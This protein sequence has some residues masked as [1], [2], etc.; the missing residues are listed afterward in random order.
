MNKLCITLVAIVIMSC[1][2]TREGY[3]PPVID[4][5]EVTETYHGVDVVDPYRNLENL[6]DS[7]VVN[8]MKGQAAHAFNTLSEIS[9]KQK[10]IDKK[11]TN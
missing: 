8:L 9:G 11:A 4:S 1:T 3:Q 2:S 6:E 10:L 7:T 5:Q